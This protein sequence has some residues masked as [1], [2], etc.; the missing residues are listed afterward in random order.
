MMRANVLSIYRANHSSFSQA[1]CFRLVGL[2]LSIS[3]SIASLA[4]R[5]PNLR[6]DTRSAPSHRTTRNHDTRTN[7]ISQI[8]L[9]FSL[10]FLKDYFYL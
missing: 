5:A 10:L 8:K 2:V 4:R 9:N 6:I 3:T 1:D 7:V